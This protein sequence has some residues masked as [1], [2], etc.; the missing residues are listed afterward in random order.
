MK[1]H[2]AI[3]AITIS[4]IAIWT[5]NAQ[6]NENT[7]TPGPTKTPT[8]EI[9][10]TLDT[11]NGLIEAFTQSDLNVLTGN[12]QRPN[13]V[14]WFEEDLY[15]VCNGDW[16]LY[17]LDDANGDTETYIYGIRN[18]HSLYAERTSETEF[19]L[20]IPDYD[21]N[22]LLR[23]NRA[24]APQQITNELEGPWGINY[25]D[26]E[27]FLITNLQGNNIVKVNRSGNIEVVLEGMRAPTGIDSNETIVF[28]AN[29]GSTRRSIEWINKDN[30]LNRNVEARPQVLVS[31]LQNTTGVILAEDG[32]LYFSYAIGRRGVVGRIDPLMCMDEECT[33]DEV[34]IV[35]Y[36]ELDAPLAGM[37][38]SPD[39]R[40][41]VHTIYR[42]E[43][44]WVQLPFNSEQ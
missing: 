32:Y 43:I 31:G 18:A 17:R 27:N 8:Q 35:L 34:E 42:P 44:Y 2:T 13:G 29:N 23:V 25:I 15:A 39:M 38:I 28:V 24:R 5:V 1:T 26:E 12:V 41:F 36:T 6:Q 11:E 33:N 4:L 40:L 19:D 30:L 20:W 16:T 37:T 14:I 21:I 22:A 9:S 7:P 10:R 3:V